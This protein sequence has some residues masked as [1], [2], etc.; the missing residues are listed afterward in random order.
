MEQTIKNMEL[1]L[2]RVDKELIKS[3]FAACKTLMNTYNTLFDRIIFK[4]TKDAEEIKPNLKKQH[5][6]IVRIYKNVENL[7][8]TSLNHQEYKDAHKL[9]ETSKLLNR[10]ARYIDS[11]I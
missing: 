8:A 1:I 2:V 11:P 10:A 6:T 4:D 7:I 9:A 3:N 5:E